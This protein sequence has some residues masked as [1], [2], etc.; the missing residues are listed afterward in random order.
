MKRGLIVLSAFVLVGAGIAAGAELVEKIMVRVNDRLSFNLGIRYD[1]DHAFSAAQQEL[2]ELN[3]E[4]EE[5]I[6]RI[7]VT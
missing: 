7:R 2:D 5:K 1:H 6:A 4:V 3:A